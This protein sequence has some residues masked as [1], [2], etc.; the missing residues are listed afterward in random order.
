MAQGTGSKSGWHAP[1]P[2]RKEK[3]MKSPLMIIAGALITSLVCIPALAQTA[4]DR[5]LAQKICAD[6]SG[7][8]LK[9]CVN[10]QLRN[11]D[12][13]NSGNRQQCEARKRASRQCA[14]LFGWDFRQCTQRMIPE[15]DCS[16]LRARDRQQCELNQSAYVAC[17]KKSGEEHMNCLRK[18]F[19]G[20]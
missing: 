7:S 10:Q 3:R 9:I 2:T 8:A 4:E 19:S 13:S 20:Q 5:A 14:G 11:F 1:P 16:T 17:S 18:H 12:C 6:Q 15:I